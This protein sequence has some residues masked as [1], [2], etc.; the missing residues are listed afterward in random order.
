M[1]TYF[2]CVLLAAT[3]SAAKASSDSRGGVTLRNVLTFLQAGL[4]VSA[5]V[6]LDSFCFPPEWFLELWLSC[7]VFT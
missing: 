1:Q 7:F 5:L 6:T 4:K 3:E 2:Q